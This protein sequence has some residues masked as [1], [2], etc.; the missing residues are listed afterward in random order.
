MYCTYAKYLKDQTRAN[1]TYPEQMLQ[2][3][4]LIRVSTVCYSFSSLLNASAGSTKGM[5]KLTLAMLN[6]DATPTSNFQ[7]IRLLDP[8]CCYKFTY[9][10]ANS[11]NPDQLASSEAN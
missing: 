9:L 4:A 8:D 3:M 7:P 11:A 1:N 6:K 2:N 10:M 5:F